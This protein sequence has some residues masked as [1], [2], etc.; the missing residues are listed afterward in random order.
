MQANDLRAFCSAITSAWGFGML[1]MTFATRRWG[2]LGLRI[3]PHVFFLFSLLTILRGKEKCVYVGSDPCKN[4]QTDLDVTYM[5]WHARQKIPTTSPQQ[6]PGL[7]H[8]RALNK[9]ALPENP[10]QIKPDDFSKQDPQAR[11]N[12]TH[13]NP[14]SRKLREILRARICSSGIAQC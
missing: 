4:Q 13:C 3:C 10:I 12:E 6:R 1:I 11:L 7:Q 8:K 14:H 9:A 2:G 5:Y